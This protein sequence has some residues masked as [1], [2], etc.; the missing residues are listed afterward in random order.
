LERLAVRP[1]LYRAG[2]PFVG[3]FKQLAKNFLKQSFAV[4]HAGNPNWAGKKHLNRFQRWVIES[5][6]DRNTQVKT[7]PSPEAGAQ[8][9][10]TGGRR[11]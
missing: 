2:P 10:R 1:D 4:A 8:G 7:V 11:F 9:P 5:V 3:S 6:H